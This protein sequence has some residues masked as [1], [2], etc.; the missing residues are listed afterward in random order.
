M[1]DLALGDALLHRALADQEGACD[2]LTRGGDDAQR[3]RDLAASPAARDGRDEEQPQNVV[4]IMLASSRWSTRL[5]V[6]EIR[7]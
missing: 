7:R 1:R 6:V 2:L 4:A 3:Q 5:G